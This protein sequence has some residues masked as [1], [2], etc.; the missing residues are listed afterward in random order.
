LEV[1]PKAAV[2]D[3]PRAME[4]V[5]IQGPPLWSILP[6]V[7]LLG[8]IAC[9]PLLFAHWWHKH[10][11]KVCFALA[12]LVAGYYFFARG[13]SHALVHAGV[14]YVQ[15]ITLI[16]S[17]FIVS[18]GIHITVKGE[19]TPFA[20]VVFLLVGALLANVLGTTGSSMLLIRPWIR[21]NKYRVTAHHI[22]FFIFIVSNVGGAMTPVGDPPLFLGYLKGVP[23]WWVAQHCWPA[24]VFAMA[25][26]LSIFYVIDRRNY[27][28]APKSVRDILAEP[29]DH[30]KFD[31]T[32]NLFFLAV[33]FFA[34]FLNKPLFLRESIM[35]AAALGSWFLTPK[36]VHQANE[37]NFEPIREVAIFFVAIFAT[38]IPALQWLEANASSFGNPTVPLFYW[39]S[40]SLSGVLDNAP[41]YASFL[42]AIFGSFVP[43]DVAHQAMAL[44][45]GGIGEGVAAPGPGVV[46]ALEAA[47]TYF[48]EAALARSITLDQ[49]N[50][51]MVL[52]SSKLVSYLAAISV[53]AVFFG[54]ATYIG[55]GPNFMVRS[56]AEHRKVHV[57]SFFGYVL[58]FTL[59]FLL[60]VLLAVGLLFY[61]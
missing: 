5:S 33:I 18:G 29:S 58:R 16:G 55:N 50:M 12:A 26:L 43:P 14:D 39:A 47:R 38:M 37:F 22:V 46:G 17:L 60:P 6:F 34:V 40:G 36:R 42:S 1:D 35:A 41:T 57:P 10:Y 25:A 4:H 15:F 23:F 8:L 28:R 44:I 24:W 32:A 48:P 52:G 31:G 49:V 56:I 2:S 21:M 3:N 27:L 11:P 61:S 51:A 7:A 13:D 53:A 9:G 19:A 45:N 54:A 20:N 30:W 59:P